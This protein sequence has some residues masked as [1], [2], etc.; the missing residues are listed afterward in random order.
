[1]TGAAPAHSGSWKKAIHA[2]QEEVRQAWKQ[3][4][5]VL[6]KEGGDEAALSRNIRAMLDAMPP[7]ETEREAIKRAL[8][9]RFGKQKEKSAT[10]PD[11]TKP[12]EPESRSDRDARKK[13]ER[14]W[15]R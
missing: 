13:R 9:E 7:V 8:R 10:V 6:E 4:A 11:T 15:E 12:P 14:D 3:A 1:M 5:D 2:G